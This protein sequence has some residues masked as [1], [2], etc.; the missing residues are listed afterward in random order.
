MPDFD[1]DFDMPDLAARIEMLSEGQIDRL[2]FGVVRLDP[3]GI[4]LFYNA[5][6]ARLSGYGVSPLGQ[7]F[8]TIARSPSKRDFQA[9][10]VA[11]QEAG[12]VDLEFAFPGEDIDQ[13]RDVRVSVQSAR[14]G[15]VWVFMQRDDSV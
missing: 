12:A 15:G 8:L 1:I 14:Q 9:R 13:A 3:E 11:A 10:I 4:I 7:S 5:T 6:E 2:P